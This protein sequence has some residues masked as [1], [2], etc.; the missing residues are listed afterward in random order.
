M[1]SV[2]VR[3]REGLPVWITLRR[4]C[5]VWVRVRV[6]NIAY[7][8][9]GVVNSRVFE[10]SKLFVLAESLQKSRQRVV[11]YAIAVAAKDLQRSVAHGSEKIR[12]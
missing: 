8:R 12:H 10:L 4:W 1:V 5:S 11:G 3:V 9:V 7:G 6:V 2:R